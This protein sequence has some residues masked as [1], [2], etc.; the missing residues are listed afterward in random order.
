MPTL[1][2]N[3]KTHTLGL[4]FSAVLLCFFPDERDRYRK[5][6]QE[7]RSQNHA[8]PE[9]AQ[10]RPNQKPPHQGAFVQHRTRGTTGSRPKK[11]NQKN[12]KLRVD[13]S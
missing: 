4:C 8:R 6:D 11:S 2:K 13:F 12:L 9:D 10:P 1:R 7:A 3:Q 5:K